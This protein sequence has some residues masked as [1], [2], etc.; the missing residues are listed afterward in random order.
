MWKQNSSAISAI[1]TPEQREKFLRIATSRA[2][3]PVRRGRVWLLVKSGT[4]VPVDI[5]TGISDGSFTEIVRGDLKA[6]QEVI[7]GTSQLKRRSSGSG[8]RRFGF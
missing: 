4:P 5:I 1:L 6:G 8:L 7:A 2:A 3:N